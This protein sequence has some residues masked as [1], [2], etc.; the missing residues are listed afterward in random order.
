M[1]A[2]IAGGDWLGRG[3]F[4][5]AP[6][7]P[8]FLAL[9]Y[10]LFDDSVA[11]VRVVQ[12]V[13]SAGSCAL[14]AATGI[15]LFGKRGAIAGALLAIYPPAIFLDGLIEKAPLAAFLATALLALI[16]A[17][18]ER[19]TA[20]RWF[21]AGAALG[22]LALARENALILAIPLL[23]WIALG[24]AARPMR[25]RLGQALIF[26]AGCGLILIPVGP[27]NLAVGG[28]FIQTT[29]QSAPIFI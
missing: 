20:R 14:L 4:Y 27:R 19:M 22:L 7:Y 6:L 8:Y 29:S 16:C 12:A 28:D 10:R 13:L 17:P 11:T 15:Q 1:G 21:A 23:C 26:L 3:V 9:V 24:P 2:K 25:A 5:Q 18:V